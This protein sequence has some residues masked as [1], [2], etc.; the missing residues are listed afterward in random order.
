MYEAAIACCRRWA[1]SAQFTRSLALANT[2]GG[3]STEAMR[4]WITAERW[5]ELRERAAENGRDFDIV[6]PVRAFRY[7]QISRLAAPPGTGE[8]RRA[9]VRHAPGPGGS[10]E[11]DATDSDRDRTARRDLRA[12]NDPLARRG[13]ADEPAGGDPRY[14]PLAFVSSDPMPGTA[15]WSNISAADSR[16]A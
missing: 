13:T 6:D 9:V 5:A 3:L 12:G 1:W 14:R 16:L 2:Y 4:Q 15:R 7:G 8:Y 10:A 11:V